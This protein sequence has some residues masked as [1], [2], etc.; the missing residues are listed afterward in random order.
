MNC[1]HLLKRNM[2]PLLC[3]RHCARWCNSHTPKTETQG[4]PVFTGR[5]DINMHLY[6]SVSIWQGPQMAQ[7]LQAMSKHWGGSSS[8]AHPGGGLL[9]SL[10]WG[11]IC[12][13]DHTGRGLEEGKCLGIW[14]PVTAPRGGALLN[15]TTLLR[16]LLLAW[17]REFIVSCL[18]V[19]RKLVKMCKKMAYYYWYFS[20]QSGYGRCCK[21]AIILLWT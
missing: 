11:S 4:A 20:T 7:G 3:V 9:F 15:G 10:M 5:E 17:Y 21:K 12:L 16:A 8:P 1:Y 18:V 13:E 6:T 14:R 19:N 2:N